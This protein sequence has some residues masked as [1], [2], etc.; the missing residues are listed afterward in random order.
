MY[1]EQ[2]L[3][4]WG[5]KGMKW[6]V[7]RARK[8]T[9]D[10]VKSAGGKSKSKTM[11]MKMKELAS[12]PKVKKGAKIA[13]GVLVGGLAAAALVYGG[14]KAA[15]YFATPAVRAAASRGQQYINENFNATRAASRH[16]ISQ[17]K[18]ST[19]RKAI[20]ATREQATR[21]MNNYMLSPELVNR[22]GRRR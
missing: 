17:M 22:L 18:N 6:G 2:E 15:S 10:N 9:G 19:T 12:N 1:N 13:A 16:A 14:S 4:H 3:Y 21:A 7:R 8:Q 20:S 11:G 5:V